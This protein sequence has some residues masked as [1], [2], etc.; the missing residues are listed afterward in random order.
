[1]VKDGYYT[2]RVPR[3]KCL[4]M[5]GMNHITAG[6]VWYLAAFQSSSTHIVTMET[7]Y[8]KAACRTLKTGFLILC[9]CLCTGYFFKSL[10]FFC[11]QYFFVLTY[12]CSTRF[13]WWIQNSMR[14]VSCAVSL[15]VVCVCKRLN[16]LDSVSLVFWYVT[17]EACYDIS[18]KLNCLTV[19][20][21]EVHCCRKVFHFKGV[22]K[23]YEE[24]ANK[25]KSVVREQI[26]LNPK[27]DFPMI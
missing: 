14:C 10:Q 8:K 18:D 26:G 5:T 24:H 9:F 12:K 17:S 6:C 11:F 21:S 25:L 3:R 13:G 23:G 1:M 27:R 15:R 2:C 7:I 4:D 22:A 19:C 16:K 20:L